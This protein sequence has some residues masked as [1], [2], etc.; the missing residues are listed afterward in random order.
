MRGRVP[1]N[2]GGQR[3]ISCKDR[4][5]LLPGRTHLHGCSDADGRASAQPAAYRRPRSPRANA[6]SVLC[7][8]SS[9]AT[10]PPFMQ[11]ASASPSTSS[12]HVPPRPLSVSGCFCTAPP[13]R[14]SSRPQRPTTRITLTRP[15]LCGENGKTEAQSR[16]REVVLGCVGVWL[17]GWRAAMR[18][19]QC[20]EPRGG[21]ICSN[22]GRREAAGI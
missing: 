12:R 15:S 2:R 21:R 9:T 22:P 3:A 5:R 6:L 11:I 7:R 8:C 19:I 13:W 1:G 4:T 17:G 16:P 18:R 14:R 10:P 20:D